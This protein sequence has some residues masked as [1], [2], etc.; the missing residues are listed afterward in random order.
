M[1]SQQIIFNPGTFSA[2]LKARIV[3]LGIKQGELAEL[4]GLGQAN[5]SRYVNGKQT[6]E[7][8]PAI[9]LAKAL[10]C[11]LDWLAG[12]EGDTPQSLDLAGRDLIDLPEEDQRKLSQPEA[13]TLKKALRVIRARGLLGD[14]AKAL[15]QNIEAFHVM[16]RGQ[17]EQAAL[18]PHG[19]QQ[20]GE[21]SGPDAA[22]AKKRAGGAS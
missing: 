1:R 17:Q 13:D 2:N 9:A 12:L 14:P 19:G 3:Q 22:K 15:V 5:I 20:H 18:G 10:G 11:S 7:L 21:G 4:S 8:A 16:V 6:P